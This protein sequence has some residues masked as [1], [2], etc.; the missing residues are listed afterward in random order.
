MTR[1]PVTSKLER[2]AK[3]GT[4]GASAFKDVTKQVQCPTWMCDGK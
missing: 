2:L 4:P 1:E 3:H